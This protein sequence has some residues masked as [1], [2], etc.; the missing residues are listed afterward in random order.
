MSLPSSRRLTQLLPS[1]VAASAT[2]LGVSGCDSDGSTPIDTTGFEPVA[3]SAEG[4]IDF[5]N[6][7]V[8]PV[9]VDYLEL[10]PV[11]S[12]GGPE[13]DAQKAGDPCA[14]ATDLQACLAA[15]DAVTPQEGF[16]LGDCV[17]F[18][19]EYALIVN[20][21]DAVDV[22]TTP[23]DARSRV[24][25]VDGPIDAVFVVELA[26]YTVTCDAEA[27]GVK[28][29][30]DGYE[31]LASRI[32]SACDPVETTLYR[33]HVASTGEIT[34]L[35]SAVESSDEG[36]CI[37]RRPVGLVPARARGRNVVAAHLADV[38]RLEAASVFAFDRLEAE[39][40]E[41]GAPTRLLRAARRARA[42]EIRHAAVVGALARRYGGAVPRPVVEA[43]PA[44]DLESIAK[45]NAVEGCV[46]EAYGALVGTWQSR[47]AG[48]R[49]VRA[50]MRT[51]ARDETRHAA[52][53]FA[54]AAW[55]EPRLG[56]AAQRRVAEARRDELALLVHSAARPVSRALVSAV[57]LPDARAAT[58]LARRFADAVG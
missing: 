51:I 48:D 27:R 49:R 37:G 3:C 7:L 13:G 9:P 6:Q 55:V 21:G 2:A 1:I 17:D 28:E 22:L 5:L 44:R 12:N 35:E 29:V 33:L 58:E 23:E 25:P 39:L 54:V 10:R 41:H 19:P 53:S 32:T 14:T 24:V 4:G 26:G 46:R 36:S 8:L 11:A 43:S 31:V 56:R 20:A 38:A 15:I 40:R 18:C 50:A 57:G 30:N 45:E 47:F 42:D 34:E 52:L 16:R